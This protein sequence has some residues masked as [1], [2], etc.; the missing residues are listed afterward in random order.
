MIEMRVWLLYPPTGF[1]PLYP[2]LALAYLT[3]T[4]RAI[5]IPVTQMDLSLDLWRVMTVAEKERLR[6][7]EMLVNELEKNGSNVSQFIHEVIRKGVRRHDVIG[8][9]LTSLTFRMGTEL[10]KMI[11][12]YNENVTIVGGGQHPTYLGREIISRYPEFDILMIGEGELLLSELIHELEKTSP[13]LHKIRGILFRQGTKI[14]FTGKSL[15]PKNLNALPFPDFDDFELDGYVS[16]VL[17]IWSSRG[18]PWNRCTFCGDKVYYRERSPVNVVSEMERNVKKYERSTFLFADSA[19]N[20]NPDRLMKICD[21]VV[22]RRIKATWSGQAMVVGM[23][24]QLLQK[25]K[26]AGCIEIEYG[27]E[28]ASNK[29]LKTMR[30]PHTSKLMSDVLRWTKESEIM[31]MTYWIVG[32]PDE[33]DADFSE[34][35]KFVKNHSSYIDYATFSPF[36]VHLNS[37]IAQHP[38]KFFDNPELKRQRL[39][40][41]FMYDIHLMETSQERAVRGTEVAQKMGISI[42]PDNYR[43]YLSKVYGV[44]EKDLRFFE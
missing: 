40:V 16:P 3:S 9:S 31:T 34:T 38:E 10:A 24:H 8:M 44:P 36:Y 29:V 26:K 35:L 12:D 27:M 23:T 20:T 4:L 18:C 14:E 33:D 19:V 13:N 1:A 39:S 42:F 21:L 28:S 43:S 2:P 25:M 30:K 5:S 17:P 37:F 41:R 7:S 22:E 11:K 15:P 32:F 6:G